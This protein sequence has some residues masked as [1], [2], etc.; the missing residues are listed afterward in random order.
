MLTSR[1]STARRSRPSA[2]AGSLLFLAVVGIAG[3]SAPPDST[4]ST[5]PITV[6]VPT[7]S[8]AKGLNVSVPD[9]PPGEAAGGHRG[10]LGVEDGRLP[11]DVTVFD[12]E[13]P[14][15][16]N[17]SPDL[18]GALR[19]AARERRD[20]IAIT[21][22]SGWRSAAYQEQLL[23]DAVSEYGSR[24]EAARWVATPKT[25]PHVS[26]EAVDVD[27]SRATDWLEDHGARFGLCQVF[28][29]EPWHF[30][31]R[32][33]AV[34]HGCPRQYADPTQDPRMQR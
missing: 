19:S 31:L 6:T 23:E 7:T 18:L 30:E 22:N 5:D 3:C 16:A 8:S 14:G 13:Y 15:V 28:R 33:S 27:G 12:S 26:G 10:A 2:L 1:P 20:G 29:N 21:L 25:S 24:A 32:P 34:D 11:D 4:S 9:G 17:L